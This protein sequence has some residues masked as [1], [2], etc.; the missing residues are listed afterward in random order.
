MS[1]KCV[2][3]EEIEQRLYKHHPYY[4]LTDLAELRA[5]EEYTLDSVIRPVKVMKNKS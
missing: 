3:I 1:T 5:H 4:M 2:H